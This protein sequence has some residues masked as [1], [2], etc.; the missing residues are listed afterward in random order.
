MTAVIP[1]FFGG[2][3]SKSGGYLDGFP[4]KFDTLQ[5]LLANAKGTGF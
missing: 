5:R 2:Y 1:S 4:F 3:L